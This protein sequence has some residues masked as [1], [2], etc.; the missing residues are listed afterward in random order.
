MRL[1]ESKKREEKAKERE[2]K[3]AIKQSTP[4]RK[5]GRPCSVQDAK[6]AFSCQLRG[7]QLKWL[8][9]HARCL[10]RG[11]QRISVNSLVELALYLLQAQAIASAPIAK[12]VKSI[13]ILPIGKNNANSLDQNIA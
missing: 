3:A 2:E 11:G 12:P 13:A 5:R 6:R 1:A 7:S 9:E 4:V 10:N 8:R